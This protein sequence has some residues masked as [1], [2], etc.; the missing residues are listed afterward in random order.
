MALGL[1]L[2]PAILLRQWRQ[3]DLEPFT[4]M[5]S[6]PEVMRFFPKVL[7][8]EESRQGM[9]RLREG[10]DQR[11]WGLWAV[12]VEGEFAGFTGLAEP[13][14]SAPFTPCVE[15]GWRLRREFWGRGIAHAAAVQAMAHAFEVLRLKELVSFTVIGNDRSRKLMERL[16]FTR[17]LHGDF[18]HPS[19]PEGHPLRKHVLYRKLAPKVM[20][21]G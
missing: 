5:N 7:T 8:A 1:S 11:R 16:G 17:D 12:D 21:G 15:I 13:R 19:L 4:A 18:L 14:F 9:Q 20:N 3:E 6:D 2:S 10:I